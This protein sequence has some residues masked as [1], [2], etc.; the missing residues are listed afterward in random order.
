MFITKKEILFFNHV[1]YFDSDL[2]P[3]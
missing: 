2:E 3:N 1:Y